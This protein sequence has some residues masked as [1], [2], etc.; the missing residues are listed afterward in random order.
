[1]NE[2]GVDPGIDH[3]LAMELFHELEEKGKKI[4]S[5]VSF[6]GG[7]PAPEASNNALG[8][9]FSWSPRGVLLNTVSGKKSKI[10][11]FRADKFLCEI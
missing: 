4:K 1:M 11:K 5:F 10:F 6:C 8:Y 2:V 7:L 9:K 3:M